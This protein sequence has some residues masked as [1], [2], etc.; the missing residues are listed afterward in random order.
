MFWFALVLVCIA[1]VAFLVD[2]FDRV[3]PRPFLQ[4]L[5]LAFF[6]A[7]FMVDALHHAGT[8]LIVWH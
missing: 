1:I 6:A 8:G 5:G 4:S 7:A 3:H 2:A